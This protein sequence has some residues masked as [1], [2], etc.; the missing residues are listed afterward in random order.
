MSD[1]KEN[2]SALAMETLVKVG[3]LIEKHIESI[4][5]AP[6]VVPSASGSSL[7]DALASMKAA[8]DSLDRKIAA[9][10]EAR[11]VATDFLMKALEIALNA[12]L[13]AL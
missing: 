11:K 10:E 2:A 5:S 4:G 9:K 12:A 13:V 6:A 1:V 7:D 8:N 3:S